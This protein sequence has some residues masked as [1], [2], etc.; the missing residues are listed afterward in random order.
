VKQA[1]FAYVNHAKFCS[2][3]QPVLSNEGNAFCSRKQR[4][5]LMKLELTTDRHPPI[6]TFICGNKDFVYDDF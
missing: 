4:G 1:L 2:W 6:T 5:P 3:N